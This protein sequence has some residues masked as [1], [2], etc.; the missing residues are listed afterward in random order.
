MS[1]NSFLFVD[2]SPLHGR[3]VFTSQDIE[4]GDVVEVCHVL[5]L[6]QH[7]AERIE[8]TTLKDYVFWWGESGI[9][10]CL[11]LGLGMLYN[12]S[13]DPNLTVERDFENLQICF[14]AT[15]DISSHEELTHSYL[16]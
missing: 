14:R 8:K 13:S 2:S 4:K 6:E 3:G 7:D 9:E 5:V 12:H 11:V 10:S 16:L 15:R 1:N